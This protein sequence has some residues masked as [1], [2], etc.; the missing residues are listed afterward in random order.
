MYFIYIMSHQSLETIWE[1]KYQSTAN[2]KIGIKVET[3]TE[4]WKEVSE[5]KLQIN[6]HM[7]N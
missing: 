4:K 1:G 7:E 6:E 5:W 3:L 2:P